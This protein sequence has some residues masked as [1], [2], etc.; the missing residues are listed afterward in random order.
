MVDLPADQVN[1]EK[2]SHIRP[3]SKTIV[4]LASDHHLCNVHIPTQ[5]PTVPQ[6]SLPVTLAQPRHLSACVYR[7]VKAD[8]YYKSREP[9]SKKTSVEAT[10]SRSKACSSPKRL[11]TVPVTGVERYRK[12]KRCEFGVEKHFDEGRLESNEPGLTLAS[13]IPALSWKSERDMT[14]KWQSQE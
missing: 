9:P 10:C 11:A 7:G 4:T 6:N 14:S 5:A 12:P 2:T 3:G 1:R 8:S 13:P